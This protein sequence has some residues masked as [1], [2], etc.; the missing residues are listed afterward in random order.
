MGVNGAWGKPEPDW[1]PTL[2]GSTLQRTMPDSV[3]TYCSA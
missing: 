2:F 3:L 1:Q